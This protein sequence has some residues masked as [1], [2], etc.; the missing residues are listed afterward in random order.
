[1]G[2]KVRSLARSLDARVFPLG[3]MLAT[4]ISYDAGIRV[5]NL[6][7]SQLRT[8]ESVIIDKWTIIDEANPI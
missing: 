8:V 6:G 5:L 1:M 7:L 3:V 4:A 2:E